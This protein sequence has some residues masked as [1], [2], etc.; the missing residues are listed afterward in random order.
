M[1]FS[2]RG[3]QGGLSG[4]GA[5]AWEIQYRPRFASRRA[6]LMQ[7]AARHQARAALSDT[8]LPMPV[9]TNGLGARDGRFHV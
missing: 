2:S 8:S 4:A 9:R 7:C 5:P 6:L 3:I 1:V